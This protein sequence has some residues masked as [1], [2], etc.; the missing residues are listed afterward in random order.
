M[1][2]KMIELAIKKT[3]K[4]NERVFCDQRKPNLLSYN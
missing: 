3:L 2:D 4:E 1:L